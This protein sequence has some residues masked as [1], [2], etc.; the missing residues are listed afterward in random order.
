M[1][2]TQVAILSKFDQTIFF[3]KPNSNHLKLVCLYNI[4][5]NKQKYDWFSHLIGLNS[6]MYKVFFYICIS[7]V[8]F[9]LTTFDHILLV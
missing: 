2:N 4:N 8:L 1:N 9:L 6:L 7:H 5:E 3:I